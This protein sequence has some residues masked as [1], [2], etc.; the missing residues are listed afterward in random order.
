MERRGR[1]RVENGKRGSV[2]EK[3]SERNELLNPH[4]FIEKIH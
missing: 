1:K 2:I 4:L 3:R